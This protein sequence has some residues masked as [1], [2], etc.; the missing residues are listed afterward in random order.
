M[1]NSRARLRKINCG[2]L[3]T[4]AAAPAA[5]TGN[6]GRGLA[7]R[8]ATMGLLLLLLLLLLQLMHLMLMLLL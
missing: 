8:P 2:I 5:C 4:V 6:S 3:Q 7:G 1:Q